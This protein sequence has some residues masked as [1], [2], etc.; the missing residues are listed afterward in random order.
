M[1]D[2]CLWLIDPDEIECVASYDTFGKEKKHK[3][4]PK[5]KKERNIRVL[6]SETRKKKSKEPSNTNEAKR[7]RGKR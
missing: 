4:N 7:Q 3:N 1:I 2:I 6:M 5:R